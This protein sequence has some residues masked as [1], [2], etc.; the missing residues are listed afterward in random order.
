MI[1]NKLFATSVCLSFTLLQALNLD[2][3][4]KQEFIEPTSTCNIDYKDIVDYGDLPVWCNEALLMNEY[5]SKVTAI[6]DNFYFSYRKILAKHINVK[7]KNKIDVMV[8]N[9]L[10]KQGECQEMANNIELPDGANPIIPFFGL[11]SCLQDEYGKSFYELSSFIYDNPKYK[12]IFD[13]IFSTNPKE[14]YEFMKSNS[15]SEFLLKNILEK[16]AKDNLI[17]KTGKLI[18]SYK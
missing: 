6:M 9:M 11:T 5:E 13:E 4:L 2:E 16:A 10:A 18:K 3:M 15:N 1:F 14:Y 7:D 12:Y 8:K 17:D